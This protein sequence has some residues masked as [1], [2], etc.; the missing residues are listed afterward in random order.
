[1]NRMYI[2]TVLR[3]VKVSLCGVVGRGAGDFSSEMLRSELTEP[4]ASFSF[5]SFLSLSVSGSLYRTVFFSFLR[6]LSLSLS[7]S[8]HTHTTQ[9]KSRRE[10]YKATHTY[11]R[12]TSEKEGERTGGT[13]V[14]SDRGRVSNQSSPFANGK[15][16]TWH[17]SVTVSEGLSCSTTRKHA[18]CGWL[19]IVCDCVSCWLT[20]QF[21]IFTVSKH[22][23]LKKTETDHGHTVTHCVHSEHVY[24]QSLSMK[25]SAMFSPLTIRMQH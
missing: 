25:L 15:N 16:E 12:E 17:V 7:F 24:R 11:N 4:L 20:C 9:A 13:G 5:S 18:A 2:T 10:R 21:R 23:Y 14:H 22:R 1:M 3:R 19:T 8:A 6:S